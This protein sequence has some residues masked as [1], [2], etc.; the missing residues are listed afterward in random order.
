VRQRCMMAL[1][2][3][4]GSIEGALRRTRAAGEGR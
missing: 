1:E 3:W 2:T 4:M